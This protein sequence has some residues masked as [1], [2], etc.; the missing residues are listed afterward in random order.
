MIFLLRCSELL[1]FP[2]LQN[3]D[4]LDIISYN[5]SYAHSIHRFY[6]ITVLSEQKCHLFNFPMTDVSLVLEMPFTTDGGKSFPIQ[7]S[8]VILGFELNS[9]YC[10][11]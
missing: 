5:D 9:G 3:L 6:I 1:A 2:Q 4:L 8:A 11:L 10:P 7:R